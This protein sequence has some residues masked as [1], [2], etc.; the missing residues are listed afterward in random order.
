MSFY[1]KRH[2]VQGNYDVVHAHLFPT[3]YWV[4][5]VS[6]LIRRGKPHSKLTEHSTHNRR[7]ENLIFRPWE[8]FVH[9]GY[10]VIISVS[11]EV[12]ENLTC[13][14]SRKMITGLLLYLMGLMLCILGKQ[15]H[16]KRGTESH[17]HR[18]N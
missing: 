11:K 18:T 15:N 2:I 6:R 9:S 4:S 17:S 13:W 1:L 16:I 8:K 12:H 14:L 10:D 3:L 5:M 7:R